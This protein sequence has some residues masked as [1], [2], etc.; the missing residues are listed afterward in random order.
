MAAPTRNKVVELFWKIHP[1]LYKTTGGKVGGK[2]AGMPVL[3]L[4]TKGRKSGQPRERALTYVP[5]GNA[6]AVIASFLGE[7]R[8][9][10]WY[11]NLKADPQ[12][13][14][15]CGGKSLDVR[16]REA[17]GEERDRLWR[18]AVKLNADYDEYS[19]R[20]TRRIPIVVLEPT[21]ASR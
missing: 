6:Y 14:V 13:S 3:L 21:G 2:I 18:E 1:W 4:T 8:H 16:A 11:L 12:A 20:T 7:P 10:D 17:A 15:R 5:S 19:K 9:P